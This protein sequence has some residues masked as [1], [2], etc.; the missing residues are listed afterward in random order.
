MRGEDVAELIRL[1]ICM[2]LTVME[3]IYQSSQV[4]REDNRMD[5]ICAN[6]CT[7]TTFP[8]FARKN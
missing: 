1:S 3:K 7:I 8:F 6:K 4:T 5:P 2:L